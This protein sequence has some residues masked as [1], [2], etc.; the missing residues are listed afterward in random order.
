M[1]LHVFS[2]CLVNKDKIYCK[3][4]Y[5]F[6]CFASINN[7]AIQKANY[8]SLV[9]KASI[10]L[11]HLPKTNFWSNRATV[12]SLIIVS[13]HFCTRKDEEFD[14]LSEES[15]LPNWSCMSRH[16]YGM[17]DLWHSFINK[18]SSRDFHVI[19]SEFLIAVVF[20]NYY[21]YSLR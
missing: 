3:P 5:Y 17:S 21:S 18:L 9:T 16:C 11:A 10:V 4:E 12:L 19:K 1:F 15:F 8:N 6:V 7:H 14:K 2:I 13:M 20:N